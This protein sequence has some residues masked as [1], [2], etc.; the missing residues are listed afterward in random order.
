M[1][2]ITHNLCFEQNIELIIY[3]L[4][5]FPTI[6]AILGLKNHTNQF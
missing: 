2:Q 1:P 5:D 3:N 6:N 4:E